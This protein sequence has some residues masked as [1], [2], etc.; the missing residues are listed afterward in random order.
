MTL[1]PKN[2]RENEVRKKFYDEKSFM[3]EKVL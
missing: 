3:M 2:M 1:T